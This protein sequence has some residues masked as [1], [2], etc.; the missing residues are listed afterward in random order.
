[1]ILGRDEVLMVPY[2][3][4]CFSVRFAKGQIQGGAKIG[5]GG[6]LLQETSS[7]N[8]MA[9]ATNQMD[10]N[11]LKAYGKKCC[12]FWFHSEVKFLTRFDVF[13]DLVIFAYFNAIFIDFHAV[14]SFI[15]IYFV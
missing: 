5:H 2:K 11:D 15:C 14:K 9:T 7:S 8:R 4:C 13:L 3:C 6:P 12:Y 10:S 1:M